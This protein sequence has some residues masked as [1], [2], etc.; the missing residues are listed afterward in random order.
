MSGQIRRVKVS[1]SNLRLSPRWVRS[2]ESDTMPAL[3]K[4][5]EDASNELNEVSS[6]VDDI[7]SHMRPYLALGMD[8]DEW[9]DTSRRI[10][11]RPL[12]QNAPDHEKRRIE[13]ALLGEPQW[14][15][16]QELSTDGLWDQTVPTSTATLDVISRFVLSGAIGGLLAEQKPSLLK[17]AEKFTEGHL[18]KAVLLGGAAVFAYQTLHHRPTLQG[19]YRSKDPAGLL[20]WE[21]FIGGDI[22]GDFQTERH[23]RPVRPILETINPGLEHHF[24]PAIYESRVGAYHSTERGIIAGLLYHL[25][26]NGGRDR[27]ELHASLYRELEGEKIHF[28]GNFGDYG[29]QDGTMDAYILRD[30]LKSK[31]TTGVTSDIHNTIVRPNPDSTLRFHIDGR[32]DEV[33]LRMVQEAKVVADMRIPNNEIEQFI[34]TMIVEGGGRTSP[35]AMICIIDALKD[36]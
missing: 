21:T 12:Y 26:V 36:E 14:I 11:R 20:E 9:D 3:F 24:M 23:A 6:L 10:M 31:R 18:N 32:A 29:D 5:G 13:A 28:G 25:V 22:H 17:R 34:A 4:L 33:S 30:R 2:V 16:S 1:E 8:D 15:Y 27:N 19:S 35:D 7:Q